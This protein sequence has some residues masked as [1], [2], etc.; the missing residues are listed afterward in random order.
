[1]RR[2]VPAAAISNGVAGVFEFG[3]DVVHIRSA[4]DEFG[5]EELAHRFNVL[6]VDV[7]GSAEP[8]WPAARERLKVWFDNGDGGFYRGM[9]FDAWFS[10]ALEEGSLAR[11]VVQ[12]CRLNETDLFELVG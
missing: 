4:I 11:S 6:F 1:L 8:S 7:L 12:Y 3:K 9:D 5:W 10:K 2:A